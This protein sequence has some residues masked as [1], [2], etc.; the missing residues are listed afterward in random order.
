MGMLQFS[1]F[2]WRPTVLYVQFGEGDTPYP[3]RSMAPALLFVQHVEVLCLAPAHFLSVTETLALAEI[4]ATFAAGYTYGEGADNPPQNVGA[5]VQVHFPRIALRLQPLPL[6]PAL[7][8]KQIRHTPRI[9]A[10]GG[11]SDAASAL[12]VPCNANK[13]NSHKANGNSVRSSF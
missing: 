2:R 4:A 5:M 3:Q 8:A 9:R 13:V 7:P 10:Q 6:P 1:P 12:P 11:C